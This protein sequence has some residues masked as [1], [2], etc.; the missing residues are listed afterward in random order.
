MGL[1]NLSDE[2]LAELQAILVS[3]ACNLCDPAYWSTVLA[4]DEPAFYALL[5]EV[6]HA[7]CERYDRRPATVG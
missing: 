2:A 5:S 1:H 4:E 7:N 3:K 6:V